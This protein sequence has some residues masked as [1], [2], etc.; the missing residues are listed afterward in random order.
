MHAFDQVFYNFIFVSNASMFS[1]VRALTTISLNEFLNLNNSDIASIKKN[2]KWPQH[3]VFI[4]SWPFFY[5]GFL[6]S[7]VAAKFLRDK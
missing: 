2:N 7:K 4:Y 1:D 6:H 3:V 5:T